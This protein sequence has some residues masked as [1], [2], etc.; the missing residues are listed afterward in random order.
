MREKRRN[1][2][3]SSL[4]HGMLVAGTLFASLAVQAASL[5]GTVNFGSNGGDGVSWPYAGD[6]AY[7]LNL[8]QGS[9]SAIQSNTNY[10]NNRNSMG[11]GFWRYHCVEMMLES[12]PGYSGYNRQGWVTNPTTSSYAWDRNKIWSCL[13]N[14]PGG[15]LLINIPNW[16]SYMDDGTGKL[17]T[18]M[19]DAYASFCAD[20]VKA[21]N[22]D[23]T[24]GIGYF[25]VLNEKN[26]TYGSNIAEMATIYKKCYDAMK[27]VDNTIKVGGPA[28][29]SSWD[30]QVD[31]F[32]ANAHTKLDF[33]S[34]HSY[35]TG[36][37]GDSNQSVF[38]QATAVGGNT[39][40]LR[41]II[42]KY[43]STNIPIF[44]N[45]FNISYSPPDTKMN[46]EIGMIYDAI[47][48]KYANTAGAAGT[49]AWSEGDGWY[50]K[51]NNDSSWT[52]RPSSYLFQMFNERMKG[53]VASSSSS[54]IKKLEVY[55]VT[56]GT[57]RACALINRSEVD[58]TVQM[59]FYGISALAST[60][61]VN[62]YRVQ[63]AS[64]AST[65]TDYGTVTSSAGYWLPKN[66]VIV[67]TFAANAG[68]SLPINKIIAF[69]ALNNSRFVSNDL[70]DSRILKASWATAV[71]SWERFQ[72]IDAGGGKVALLALN[73][74]RYVSNDLN[75]SR[76]A[77]A[78]WATGI[79]AWEKFAWEDRGNNK[80]AL[81]ADNNGRYASSD[82]NN[83]GRLR[84]D[85]ATSVGNWEEFQW[86]ETP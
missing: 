50:G 41:D 43:T 73:N 70:N 49:N 40:W 39:K 23:R 1:A 19:Y 13:D 63:G 18:N 75:N 14:R 28:F 24:Y 58:Q 12:R 38:D 15:T 62:V 5:T 29:E 85:W 44:H 68:S 83:G 4:L 81:R 64:L 55:A 33:V 32:V 76:H 26:R 71:G 47:A 11:V 30:G 17:R 31:G 60:T 25:E 45:E 57:Y 84:F 27:L 36:N 9:D 69:K 72:V 21:V 78:D 3:K 20:L 80:F 86:Q 34:H 74:N 10:K 22:K 2:V 16:P 79:G 66:S 8:Q 56:N 42:K 51:L 6:W 53:N 48:L 67:F 35:T 7:G 52:R 54:D 61:V 37:G 82:L 77:R 65:T 46:N 59:S